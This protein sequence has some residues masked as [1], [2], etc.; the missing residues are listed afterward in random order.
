MTNQTRLILIIVMAV[1]VVAG[2]VAAI[3]AF[4]TMF[5]TEPEPEAPETT[6]PP[7]SEPTE[8]TGDP[9]ALA[10]V[11]TDG[12]VTYVA[13]LEELL[14]AIA[15][16][17]NSVITLQQDISSNKAIELPYS[18]TIDLA[19]HT[20]ATNPQQG[21]G[22]QI[23]E[24]GAENGVTT[25]KNGSLVSYSDSIR[26]K[27]GGI[28]LS[29]MQL[30]TTYGTSLVLHDTDPA[31]KDLNRV[32]NSTLVSGGPCLGNLAPITLE[33]TTLIS[34]K[35]TGSKLFSVAGGDSRN[36]DVTLGDNVFLYSYGD[37]ACND[38]SV[39]LGK[40]AVKESGKT[41]TAGESTWENMTLWTTE[42]DKQVLNILMI[43]NSFCYSYVDELYGMA[44]TLGYQLN[45][46]NL[47]RGGCSIKSHYNWLMNPMEGTGKC[48]YYVTGAMGRFKH[49]TITTLA[50]AL[51]FAQWDVIS[52]QQHFDVARTL[53]F[54]AGWESCTPYASDMY[55]YLKQNYPDA[56]LYWQQT[57]SYA[58]GYQHPDNR[59]GPFDAVRENGDVYNVTIQ[60][61]QYEV[62]RDVSRAICE[63][64][65]I[66]IIP[67]GDAWQLARAQVGDTL[68]KND[69][70]HDGDGAGGQYLNACV[71]LEMLTGESCI[72]N[73]WRPSDYILFETKI[74]VLQEAAH[75][76]VAAIYG[77]DF[78]R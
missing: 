63:E 39:F 22:L 8:T 62:I 4:T 66:D 46:T 43:G 55:A 31:W 47:Y 70:C 75:E 64:N 17:G 3:W 27:G 15:P 72:G 68:N 28:V 12:A 54:E 23:Q 48:E 58:V 1:V 61:R 24:A 5:A 13:S 71:W 60:T 14:A 73:T 25:L 77:Q 49:P 53:N 34:H 65:G 42:S 2:V 67:T 69:F 7:A 32:E 41:A 44:E 29:G 76:A 26:V 35:E 11:E 37:R 36:G 45:I 40:T 51:S 6:D 38:G 30:Q 52:C 59:G 20:V 18:C 9:N 19:G 16:S 10:R 78:A 50:D 57:W 33:N 56:K 21:L 74:T